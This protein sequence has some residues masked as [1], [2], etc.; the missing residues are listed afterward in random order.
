VSQAAHDPVEGGLAALV[1]ATGVVHR[2]RSVDGQP[3]EEAVV[4]E[5]ARPVG[6]DQRAVG[7][8]GV[9]DSL[10]GA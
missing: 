2:A 1:D 4:V 9:D 6:V 5:E 3:D 7:L 8:D 10:P